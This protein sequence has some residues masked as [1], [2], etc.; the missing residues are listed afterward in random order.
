M[1]SDV[2]LLR[3]EGNGDHLIV[4]A[5]RH[6]P[7]GDVGLVDLVI[8]VAA[9]PFRGE[10]RQTV[11][12]EDLGFL[13]GN[14][15]RMTPSGELVF[16]GQRMLELCLATEPQSR[17]DGY[18]VEVSLTPSGDD[19]FPSIRYLLFDQQPFGADAADAIDRLLAN[20]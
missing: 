17:G 3:L 9:H 4:G 12:V 14:L 10:V 8:E 20:P 7:P 6:Q 13:A 5:T 1:S 2:V 11:M 16:G 18:V 19:P 15:R